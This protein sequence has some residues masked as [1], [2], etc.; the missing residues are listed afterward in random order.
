MSS[1]GRI[2]RAM[3]LDGL[4]GAVLLVASVQFVPALQK[5]RVPCPG[6]LPLGQ[7]TPEDPQQN[8]A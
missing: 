7:S 4:G 1:I 5:R 6:G 3:A 8:R 2:V